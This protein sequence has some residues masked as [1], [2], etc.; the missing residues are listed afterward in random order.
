M[1]G[2]AAGE[3]GRGRGDA[4]SLPVRIRAHKSPAPKKALC[5]VQVTLAKSSE[6]GVSVSLHPAGLALFM[7]TNLSF[8]C[9]RGKAFTDAKKLSIEDLFA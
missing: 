1:L 9:R 2:R 7:A 4:I 6:P 8:N 5:S 3:G